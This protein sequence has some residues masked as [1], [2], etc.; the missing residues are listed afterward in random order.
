VRRR[1]LLLGASAAAL[2]APAEAQPLPF[3][4]AY[5]R[6]YGPSGNAAGP[7]TGGTNP[8]IDL[9]FITSAAAFTTG[10]A[11]DS[12]VTFSRADTTAAASYYDATGVLRYGPTNIMT[13]SQDQTAWTLTNT[14]ATLA[15]GTAPDGSVTMNRIA[16]TA[17]TS[18]HYINRNIAV[19]ASTVYTVSI[20][21]KAAERQYLQLNYDDGT[22]G[23][24]A[25]FDLT[26]GTIT[27]ALT[28]RGTGSALGAAITAIGNGIYRCSIT[29]SHAST[30][31]RMLVSLAITA[32]PAVA[33]SY[34]GSSSSGLLVWGAQMEAN[35]APGPY[36]ATVAAALSGPRFDYGASPGGVTNWIRNSTMMGATNGTLS[37]SPFM[38]T[39]GTSI[40]NGLTWSLVGSGTESGIP[41][42]DISV[43][44]TASAVTGQY[45]IFDTITASGG[46][47]WTG[48]AYF[49]LISGTAPGF[50]GVYLF[51]AI[52]GNQ[53]TFVPTSAGLSTQR[54]SYTLTSS[55]NATT[56]S[57]RYRYGPPDT[58]TAVSFT[59]RI[60]A[61]QLETGS[62]ASTWVPTYGQA[63]NSG[64]TPKGLLIEEARTN[65]A[66]PSNAP[67]TLFTA[68]ASTLTAAQGVAPDGTVA[69]A[70]LAEDATTATHYANKTF[71]VTASA[72]YTFS[73]FAQAQQDTFLQLFYDDGTGVNGC[74]VNFNLTTGAIAQAIAAFGAGTATAASIQAAGNGIYR[75]SIT[76][77][78][79][80]STTGR[81]GVVLAQVF[82][83]SFATVYAGSTSNGLLIWGAQ[84]EATTQALPSSYIPAVSASQARALESA[85][86][87]L[88]PPTAFTLAADFMVPVVVPTGLLQGVAVIDDGTLANRIVLR[89]A[90]GSINSSSVISS[91]STATSGAVA[92]SA[93]TAYKAAF[94]SNGP[95]SLLTE[96]VGGVVA[97]S[98]SGAQTTGLTRVQLGVNGVNSSFLEGW[99]RRLRYYP[100]A[101]SSAQ[102]TQI[103]S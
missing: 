71:T 11:L 59:I 48:G 49:R 89:I 33:P 76:G 30:T 13:Q 77:V 32:N 36:V 24:Y 56:M 37:A 100:Q 39:W 82:N 87:A 51:D 74:Y 88:S 73:I 53:Q 21:A 50:H 102:L 2:V 75:C 20:Y 80:S 55:S 3:V 57:A 47:P 83:A 17:T 94:V 19:V 66:F 15:S 10:S 90:G 60:G 9:N 40:G 63:V 58:V 31:G 14:T 22:N 96:A 65:L 79:T 84:F 95:A 6:V 41:Y 61:P 42:V 35:S 70:R 64:A 4:G 25:T 34:A 46:Q 28:A 8:T 18:T 26:G 54:V 92:A 72:I 86:L 81:C 23:A 5:K 67:A 103:T 78:A 99:V 12:R 45:I 93:N 16:E 29:A 101:L 44:G 68:S 7:V 98:S 97:A 1:D 69:M 91:A 52:T 62:S 85:A 27:G 43:S 38:G